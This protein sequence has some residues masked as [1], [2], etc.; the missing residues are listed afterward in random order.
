MDHTDT[1]VQLGASS[2]SRDNSDEVACKLEIEWERNMRC[3]E[4]HERELEE[5]ERTLR[6]REQY[7]VAYD[8][9]MCARG[10]GLGIGQRPQR[11]RARCY[12]GDSQSGKNAK[13]YVL[14]Q[15]VR[16]L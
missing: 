7:T 14:R 2:G 6:H 12:S 13:G 16:S 9:K 4:M 15:L 3:L 1:E 10:N 5:H 8:A 11:D